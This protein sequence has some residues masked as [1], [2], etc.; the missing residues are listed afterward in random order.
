MILNILS[1]AA[2]PATATVSRVIRL[3]RSDPAPKLFITT[4]QD[5][6]VA[7]TKNPK[8]GTGVEDN[9]VLVYI[10][11]DYGKKREIMR[12]LANGDAHRLIVKFVDG[13]HH[14][15]PWKL[16]YI[17]Q[18][19]EQLLGDALCHHPMFP[20]AHGDPYVTGHTHEVNVLVTLAEAK[21]DDPTVILTAD[22]RPIQV[23]AA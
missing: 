11:G 19:A 2:G 1:I 3:V 5:E 20:D 21:G 13:K 18:R 14:S 6:R 12:N 8:T 15:L 7:D 17:A 10:T 22:I 9:G 4:I 23:A 16:A